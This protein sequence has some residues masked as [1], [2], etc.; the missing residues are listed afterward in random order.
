[1]IIL[2]FTAM[3]IIAIIGLV[4]PLLIPRTAKPAARGDYAI[5]VYRNQLMHIEHE[6]K[7]RLMTTEQAE[8][9]RL[10]R[11]VR[12]YVRD[13]VQLDIRDDQLLSLDFRRAEGQA[14]ITRLF[15]EAYDLLENGQ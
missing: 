13:I 10:E 7:R 9:L 14:L 15:E 1:M 8:A 5:G 11:E 3:T 2:V 6:V 12:Q 4:F